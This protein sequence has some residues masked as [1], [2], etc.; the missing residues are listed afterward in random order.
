MPRTHPSHL[1]GLLL[2]H[3]LDPIDPKRILDIGCG[4]G[5]N[6]TWIAATLPDA[7][8]LGVDLASTTI[9]EARSYAQRLQV[10]NI[11]FEQQNFES[12]DS[13]SFDVILACGLYSWVDKATRQNLLRFIDEHL[14]PEGV[15]LI[16][17]H[18]E[19][20]PWRTEDLL[21]NP[22]RVRIAKEN[23]PELADY[24]EGLLFH[25]ALAAISDPIS[26]AQF[27]AALPTGLQYLCDAKTPPEPRFHEAVII[28]SGRE[29][30][31]PMLD[32]IWWVT[33]DSFPATLQADGP[34]ERIVEVLSMPRPLVSRSPTE[35]PVAWPPARI[36]AEQGES[37]VLSYF[38]A[39][40]ELDEDDRMLLASLDGNTASTGDS[41]D[42]FARAGLL[43]A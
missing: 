27:Q 21:R 38:G 14:T 29:A 42:F 17:F 28:R 11:Q 22:D 18:E 26:I 6:L 40:V 8:C 1:G 43:I 37:N 20:R 10:T 3:G 39:E 16:S 34:P 25:D 7:K 4:A 12:I 23:I 19:H 15:A 30:G 33:E 41:I 35:R 32:R 24:D 31:D 13:D 5:R 36:L 2:V 9:H